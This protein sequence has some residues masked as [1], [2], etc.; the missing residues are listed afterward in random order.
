ML[1]VLVH[2]KPQQLIVVPTGAGEARTLEPGPVVRYSRAVWDNTGRRV[3]FSGID[4]QD[5]ERV[6]VQDA[7]GGP[8]RA[9]TAEEVGLPKIGRPVSPDGRRV[10]ALGPD[11]LPALYPL[12]GGEPVAIPGLGENDVPIC[13]TPDG[14]EL[15]VARYEETPP[16]IERVEVA[17]GRARPWNRLGRSAPSGLHGQYRILVTPDGESYAYG[18]DRR[19]SDLYLTSSSMRGR[20]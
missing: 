18:Y 2:T 17:S 4:G 8:P 20:Q 9:V 13:W 14:R 16:R 1:A 12:A 7:D 19:I 6:Y 11:G 5:S 15:L 3:V 10:V